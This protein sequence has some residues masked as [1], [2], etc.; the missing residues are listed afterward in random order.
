VAVQQPRVRRPRS[1]IVVRRR[2]RGRLA[3]S[4]GR[5]GGVNFDEL[6]RKV[7]LLSIQQEIERRIYQMGYHLEDGDFGAVGDLLAHATFGADRIGRRAFR[8]RDEIREQYQRTNIV[9]PEGGRRTK[10]I[11]SNIVVEIDLD[12]GTATSTTSFTVAQQVPG[13]PFS[14]LVAGRYE[15]EW[16]RVDSTWRWVDRYVVAQYS[17]DL[18]KHMH[19]GTQP[20]N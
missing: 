2:A 12:G 19:S 16:E 17:N 1:S 14:L 20:Y 18:G 5:G 4:L 11:Y 3:A 7:D 13:E 9:Y 8:G 10:E 15:D 6:A